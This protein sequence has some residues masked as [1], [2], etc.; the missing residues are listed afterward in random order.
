MKKAIVTLAAASVLTIGLSGCV[1]SVDGDGFEGHH[2]SWEDRE[3]KN[4]KIIADLN[5]DMTTEQV[6][7]RLGT[8][9]FNELV[10][11]EDDVY[12]VLFYRTHRTSGDGKTTKD[13]CTPVVMRNGLLIGWGET[14]YQRI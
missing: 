12:Q 8:P 5:L 7:G 11:R 1:I 13:E 14:A 4:R 3:Y 9:D 6:R 10:Q 2:A